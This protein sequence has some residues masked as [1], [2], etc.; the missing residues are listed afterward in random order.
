MAEN[1]ILEDIAH[2]IARNE[3][4]V[5]HIVELGGDLAESRSID[6]FFY[7]P[8]EQDAELLSADLR[9]LAFQNV[10]ASRSRDQWSVTGEYRG[11]VAQITERAFVERLAALAAKYLGDFDGW[12]TAV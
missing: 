2:H 12:G 1:P 6:F 11:S 3:K 8:E 4:L 7:V 5:E 9:N 10:S